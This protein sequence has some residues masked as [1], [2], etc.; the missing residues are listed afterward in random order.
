MDVSVLG[1]G[2]VGKDV[3]KSIHFEAV[4]SAEPTLQ[5][6]LH[7]RGCRVEARGSVVA[8]GERVD[9]YAVWVVTR[10]GAKLLRWPPSYRFVIGFGLSRKR[11]ADGFSL[12]ADDSHV[13]VQSSICA[14][15]M[16][17]EMTT[18]LSRMYGMERSHSGPVIH[19]NRREL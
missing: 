14:I 2:P 16:P 4:V 1:V 13:E 9:P 19:R 11:I 6:Q 15:G 10:P 5:Q 17:R 3:A 18:P 7:T 8:A 12:N